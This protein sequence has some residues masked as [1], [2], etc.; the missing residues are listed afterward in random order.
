VLAG[1]GFEFQEFSLFF[2]TFRLALWPTNP[3]SQS[4][5][6]F[7][8]K[9]K[10]ATSDFDHSIPSSIEVKNKLVYLSVNPF[11]LH[12]MDRDNFTFNL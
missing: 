9:G 10:L 7:Y 4:V 1:P 2:K 5:T 3:S 6:W 12:D 8:I 11:C